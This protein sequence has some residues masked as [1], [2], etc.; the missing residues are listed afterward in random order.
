MQVKDDIFLGSEWLAEI[1]S[2]MFKGWDDL[3]FLRQNWDG[4]LILK[5]IQSVHVSLAFVCIQR[6][7]VL[8]ICY[9]CRTRKPLCYTARTVSS[10]QIT[11]G[12]LQSTNLACD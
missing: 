10:C 4:P 1:T 8:T 12:D 7:V 11:V 6:L 5:G 9:F 2:G 3:A